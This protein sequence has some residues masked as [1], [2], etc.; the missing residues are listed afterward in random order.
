MTWSYAT[1]LP[2]SRYHRCKRMPE[3]RVT[4][5]QWNNASIEQRAKWLRDHVM[6]RSEDFEALDRQVLG[7]V[8]AIVTDLKKDKS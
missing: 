1:R 4:L 5:E 3:Q 8:K 7:E 6:I 2:I